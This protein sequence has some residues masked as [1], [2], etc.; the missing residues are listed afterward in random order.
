MFVRRS[1]TAG[2]VSGIPIWRRLP[3]PTGRD[4]AAAAAHGEKIRAELAAGNPAV[5]VLDREF[6]TQ[7][8]DPMFLEPECGIAWYDVSRKSLELVVGVQSPY[9]AAESVAYLLGEASAGFKPARINTYFAY[10]GGGFGGRDHTPFPL[11]VALAA[12]FLPGRPVRLA[13]DRYQ[14]FQGAS[15]G[16]HS[17][18]TRGLGSIA[19]GK[20]VAFAA[21]HIL[22]GGGLTNFSPSVATVGANGAIGIYNVPKVDVTT[23]ALHSRAV[24]AGSMR[25]YGVNSAD[26]PTTLAAPDSFSNLSDPAA[27]SAALFTEADEVLSSP[28]CVNCH[29]AGDRPL[30]GDAQRLHQ[31]PV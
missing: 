2:S 1:R 9:E 15:S 21:D 16:T 19:S 25:G 8:V 10:V 6:E 30:Q 17:R 22:D 24:A 4:Y 31:P 29:P 27:R 23:V 18:C 5:L 11:Y 14:Q 13:Q 3:I 20:V 7:S 12:M 26:A 28:R